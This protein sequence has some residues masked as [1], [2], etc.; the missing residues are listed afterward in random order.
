MVRIGIDLGGTNIAVGVV[1]EQH[2]I[3]ARAGTKTAL[4]RPAEAIMEDMARTAEEAVERA[5]LTWD[6]VSV[7]GI[8]TPGLC[9]AATGVVEY[10][11]NLGFRHV[12]MKEWM[13]ARLHKTTFVEND[14]SAAAFGEYIAGAGQ[15]ADSCICITLGTGVGGGMIHNGR[16]FNGFGKYGAELGHIVIEQDGIPCGCG[17]KGC[18]ECYA[19]ATALVRQ[20]KEAMAQNRSSLLWKLVPNTDGVN[21]HTAFIAAAK[22][23]QTAKAVVEHYIDN[24]CVGLADIV[25]IFQPEVICIGG[26]ISREKNGLMDKVETAFRKHLGN[27]AASCRTKVVAAKLA[28]DA[29]IIG[30]AFLDTAR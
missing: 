17:R 11:S 14:A 23:D 7:I 19:S 10:A 1:D 3:I 12:A 15:E 22:G 8:G 30:A 2:N 20:T 18:W 9:N 16:L 6:E 21:G 29:G 24:I 25:N 27:G 26:G 4:P 28:N 13:E 5:G